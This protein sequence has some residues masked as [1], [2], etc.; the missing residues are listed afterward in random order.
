MVNREKG[1][2][3]NKKRILRTKKK[4]QPKQEHGIAYYTWSASAFA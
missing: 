3:I 2:N 4:G 1:W